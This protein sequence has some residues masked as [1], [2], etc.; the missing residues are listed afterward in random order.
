MPKVTSSGCGLRCK[1]E[2][3]SGAGAMLRGTVKWFND[4]KGY[5]FIKQDNGPDIF[6]HYSDIRARGFKSLREGDHVTFRLKQN[7]KGRAEENVVEI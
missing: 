5:G 2:F 6:V 3:F 4:K 1:N 7:K